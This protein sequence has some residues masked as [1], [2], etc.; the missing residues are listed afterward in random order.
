MDNPRK[1]GEADR[2]RGEILREARR[3]KS[4]TQE[5]VASYLGISQQQYRK[6]ETG[7]SRLTADRWLLL[8]RLLDIDQDRADGK[9]EGILA[10]R[11][12]GRPPAGAGFEEQAIPYV[13]QSSLKDEMLY[14]LD[15]LKRRVARM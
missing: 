1:P 13:S 7:R 10:A 15:E 5:R 12:D 11:A 4:F 3:L 8:C 14:L 9:I 2:L 6:Y